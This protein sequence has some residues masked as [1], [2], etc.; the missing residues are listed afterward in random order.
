MIT[1]GTIDEVVSFQRQNAL[2]VTIFSTKTCNV[3]IPVKE[4]LK[5]MMDSFP[6]IPVSEVYIEDVPLAKGEY[7]VFTVPTILLFGE[8]KE[9]VRHSRI[10]E[11]EAL[12]QQLLRYSD[13][14]FGS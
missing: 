11:F 2:C 1:I 9:L 7:N 12:R 8:G 4:K 14:F 6:D 5:K 3:C 10:I 13:I